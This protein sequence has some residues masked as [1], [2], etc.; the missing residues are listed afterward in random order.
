MSSLRNIRNDLL[1]SHSPNPVNN[2]EFLML[3]N[4]NTSK[5]PDFP[6]WNYQQFELENLYQM[7]KVSF[8]QKRHLLS[9]IPDEVIF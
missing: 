6:Y 5:N 8:L 2:E 9:Q 1:I 3:Y 7:K 4:L